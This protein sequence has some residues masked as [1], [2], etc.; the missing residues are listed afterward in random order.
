MLTFTRD[1]KTTGGIQRLG[2]S[3]GRP[4]LLCSSREDHIDIRLLIGVDRCN[5]A[6]LR[7]RGSGVEDDIVKLDAVI[8]SS[9]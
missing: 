8:A 6:R 3:S 5:F 4:L 7:G 2:A 1:I 9:A